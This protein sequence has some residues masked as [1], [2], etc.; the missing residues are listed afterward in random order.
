M[1]ALAE[2]PTTPR[3]EPLDVF[4]EADRNKAAAT[5]LALQELRMLN[6]S[7]TVESI[8]TNIPSALHDALA[9]SFASR[10]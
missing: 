5:W 8:T 4:D 9:A 1:P 10:G 6:S 2:R 7:S 3:L